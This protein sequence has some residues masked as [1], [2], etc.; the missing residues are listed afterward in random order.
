[1]TAGTLSSCSLSVCSLTPPRDRQQNS[2]AVCAQR[3][4]EALSEGLE[5]VQG[6]QQAAA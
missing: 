1:M 3:N 6:Q 5:A 4:P 2:I